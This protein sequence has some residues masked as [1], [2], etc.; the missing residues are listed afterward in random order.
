MGGWGPAILCFRT[1]F[2]FTFP[3]FSPGTHLELGRLW[4]SLQSHATDPRLKRKNWVHWDSNPRPLRQGIPNPAH[5]PTRPGRLTVEN[6]FLLYAG[7]PKRL[8]EP[9]KKIQNR[10]NSTGSASTYDSL[11]SLNERFDVA[12]MAVFYNYINLPSS[13]ELSRIVPTFVNRQGRRKGTQL[14]RTI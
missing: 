1:P 11:Q 8:L 9:L 13:D 12:S 3:R 14:G 5:Q 10:V 6:G 2:L 4:L 7:A